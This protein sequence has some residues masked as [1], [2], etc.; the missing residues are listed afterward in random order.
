MPMPPLASRDITDVVDAFQVD[1]KTWMDASTFSNPA[2]LKYQY[3]NLAFDPEKEFRNVAVNEQVWISLFF[4]HTPGLSGQA[5]LGDTLYRR[6]GTILV[7]V[8]VRKDTG[9]LLM[10]E[11][12]DRAILFF[13]TQALPGM[14]FENQSPA[15]QGGDA[16][17]GWFVMDVASDF[18]YDTLRSA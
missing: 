17:E 13:E 14:S 7:R 12:S 5:A 4:R 15:E 3:D 11:I 9:R 10:D 2:T 16:E 6:F 18:K 8:Y 1:F